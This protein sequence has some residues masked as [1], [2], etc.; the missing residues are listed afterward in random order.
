MLGIPGRGAASREQREERMLSIPTATATSPSCRP[1]G[2]RAAFGDFSCGSFAG[3]QWVSLGCSE[4]W[5]GGARKVQG[6]A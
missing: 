3:S 5:A 4:I 2:N 6:K 1:C